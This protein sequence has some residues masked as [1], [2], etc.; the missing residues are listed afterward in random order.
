VRRFSIACLS[1]ALAACTA[2][3]TAGVPLTS[4]EVGV[5]QPAGGVAVPAGGS[6]SA[7]GTAA[8]GTAAV[9]AAAAGGAHSGRGA[10]AAAPAEVFNYDR[11]GA[12]RV[13]RSRGRA[14]DVVLFFSGDSG[15][16]GAAAL[17]AQRLAEK[18]AIVAGIDSRRYRDAL[19]TA[20]EACVSPSPDLEN[21]SHYVQSKLGLK[22]YIEPTLVGY[23]AGAALAYETLA[24]SPE[25]LFKSVLTIAFCPELQL[26]K[27]VCSSPNI[28]LAPRLDSS[29]SQQA[30]ELSPAK[31]LPGRWVALQGELDKTCPAPLTK[32]FMASVPGS[33]LVALPKVAHDYA[34]PGSW[35]SQYDAAYA[36]AAALPRGETK[37]AG[38]PAAVADLPLVIVPAAGYG[39]W[40]GVFLTGD[41]GWVGLDKGVSVELAK[42]NI[43]I[44]GWDSLKY[45]WSRRT[46]DGASRDLDRVIRTY[47]R[48]WGRS[49]VLLIGYSQGADTLPFM[50]NRLPEDTH[51]MVGYTTLLGISDN[52]LWEFK[53]ATWLGSPPKGIPTGPELARWSGAPYL[54]MYG[55]SDGDAACAQLTGHD[56]TVLKLAGGHHFD[57]GYSE[58]AD[59]ILSRLPQT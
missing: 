57:G 34:V 22:K 47:A 31:H 49:H 11:F 46:P 5:S 14:R 6:G 26:T 50:V 4:A 53:V 55:E 42:H 36:R 41:G 32:K 20:T 59:D 58:I 39:D 16:D 33:E 3:S 1:A 40:F 8:F 48:L 21:L 54:C 45:F 18:G 10:P 17:L 7:A 51:R 2:A 28:A 43:P 19:Q 44:V 35:M 12:V 9:G 56:G 13:Y 29:G 30:V 37:S 27:P 23:G 24:E 15:W 38:L 52:A 25:G